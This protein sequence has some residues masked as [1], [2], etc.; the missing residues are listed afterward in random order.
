[1][2]LAH[3]IPTQCVKNIFNRLGPQQTYYGTATTAARGALLGQ[4][5]GHAPFNSNTDIR[6]SPIV[7]LDE[8]GSP[9][10]GLCHIGHYIS[11][12][13]RKIDDFSWFSRNFTYYFS[14]FLQY[15]GQLDG[16]Q[17]I[18]GEFGRNGD[19]VDIVSIGKGSDFA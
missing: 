4:I 15:F 10:I 14:L 12:T 9:T 3:K 18:L 16:S 7:I 17:N 8:F 11:M 6:P 5:R 2:F 19:D 1:M 13:T